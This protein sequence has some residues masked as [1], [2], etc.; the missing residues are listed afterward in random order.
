RNG[1]EWFAAIRD[2]EERALWADKM[3]DCPVAIEATTPAGRRVGFVHANVPTDSWDELEA[4]LA[5]SPDPASMQGTIWDCMWQRD[6][7]QHLMMA[8]RFGG[9]NA[10]VDFS[11][12]G[13]DHV[14]FGHT[15]VKEP[16]NHR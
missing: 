5:Q 1:G 13:I 10:D 4:A 16:L 11:V 9:S 2:P 8:R 12:S 15:P 6:R 14:F 7:I 3:M